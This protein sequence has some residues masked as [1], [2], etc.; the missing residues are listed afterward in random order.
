MSSGCLYQFSS[1]M[2]GSGLENN[3]DFFTPSPRSRSFTVSDAFRRI[4]PTFYLDFG[5]LGRRSL[6]RTCGSLVQREVRTSEPHALQLNLELNLPKSNYST[7]A[8]LITSAMRSANFTALLSSGSYP[9]TFRAFTMLQ[10]PCE[11]PLMP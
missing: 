4:C 5:K 9:I 3:T 7:D 6:C 8:F 2:R 11:L 10:N 1:I